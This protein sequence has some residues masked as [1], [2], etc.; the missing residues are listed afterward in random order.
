MLEFRTSLLENIVKK[1]HAKVSQ[2]TLAPMDIVRG[3]HNQHK[4]TSQ[5]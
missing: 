2:H 5:D 1:N 3:L 4:G